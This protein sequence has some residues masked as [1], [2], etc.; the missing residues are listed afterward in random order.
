MGQKTQGVSY[1]TA[2]E[3]FKNGTLPVPARQL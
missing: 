2:W 3:W 1:R